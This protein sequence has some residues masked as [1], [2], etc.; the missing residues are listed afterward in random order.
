MRSCGAA[1]NRFSIARRSTPEERQAY[2]LQKAEWAAEAANFR[3]LVADRE[4]RRREWDEY[5]AR[6]RVR[7]RRLSFGLLGR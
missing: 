6:R 2:E 3:A 4:A 7:L 1:R 5:V